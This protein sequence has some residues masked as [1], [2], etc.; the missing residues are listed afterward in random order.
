MQSDYTGEYRTVS[1]VTVYLIIQ[2][3]NFIGQPQGPFCAL[4]SVPLSDSSVHLKE[5]NMFNS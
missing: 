2:V 4:I 5:I 3:N 1:T